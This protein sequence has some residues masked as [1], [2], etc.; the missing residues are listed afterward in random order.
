MN[1]SGSI[2]GLGINW[3]FPVFRIVLIL[4]GLGLTC[5]TARVYAQYT[6]LQTDVMRVIPGDTLKLSRTKILPGTLHTEP[7]VRVLWIDYASG[8]LVLDDIKVD[9]INIYYRWYPGFLAEE[10]AFRKFIKQ[11]ETEKPGIG[12]SGFRQEY[13]NNELFEVSRIRRSG[14]ISRGITAG[15]NRDVSVTSG[16]RLQLEG[17][18][19]EDI[20]ILAAITDENIPIQ[21]DGSTQQLNDFD[22][23][24]IQLKK[25]NSRLT[26]GDFEINRKGTQF[27]DFYRNVQGV[28]LDI[29]HKNIQAGVNGAVAKGK[30]HSNSFMGENGRQGPYRLSGKTGERFIIVLAGSE[31]VYVNG[32]LMLRG[33]GNDYTMDY[34]TGELIFTTQRVITNVSR[35]VVDFEYTDRF[36]NRSLLFAHYSDTWLNDKLKVAWSY[37]READNQNAP[38]DPFSQPQKQVLQAAGD[39]PG[40]AA[41]S[42]VDTAGVSS[43][44]IRYARRDTV[45]MG[46]VYERYVYASQDEQAIYKIS[47]SSVGTGNGYYIRS[48]TEI[49]GT[50]FEWV[51]PDSI[52]GRLAGDYA[53][54]TLLPLPRLLQVNDLALNY[55]LTDKMEVFSETALSIEDKNRFSPKDDKDNRGWANRTG[56]RAGGLKLGSSALVNAELSQKFVSELYQNIDRIYRMEYGREWNFNDLAARKDE[57]VTEGFSEL[58]FKNGLRFKAGGGYRMMGTDVRSVRQ[59]YEAGSTHKWLQGKYNYTRLQTR[60]DSTQLISRWQR[61]T[62][63]IYHV[64]GKIK[65]GMEIWMEEKSDVSFDSMRAGSFRFTDLKPYLRTLDSEKLKLDISYNYRRDYEFRDS[66]LLE[67]AVAHTQYYKAIFTPGDNL[68]FQ[69][70]TTY[71]D[72]QLKNDVFADQGLNNSKVL[73]NN[74]QNTFSTPNR[75]IL[76]NLIYEVTSQRLARREIRYL[77][78]TPGFGQYEWKDF[79]GNGLQELSEFVIS[80]DPSRANFIRLLVPSQ[81]LFPTVGLN[82]SGNLK[83]ELKRVLKKSKN[84]WKETIRNFSTV[85]NFRTEQRKESLSGLN[86]YLINFRDFFKDTSLLNALYNFR[87]DVY[88]FRNSSGGEL[89]FSLTD[90][91]SRLFLL[92]GDEQRNSRIWQSRQRVNFSQDISLENTLTRGNKSYTAMLLDPRNYNISSN[93]VAP[94]LNCQFTRQFRMSYGVDISRKENRNDSL[95]VDSKA[96]FQ[97]LITELKLNFRDRNNVFCK[98]EFIRIRQEGESNAAAAYEM[99]ESFRKGNNL[100]FQSFATWYLTSSLELSLNYELR[101]SEG[102]RPLH[103]GRMQVRAL[104]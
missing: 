68:S 9:S 64:Q 91:K 78:T 8:R 93:S 41:F 14:S 38:I 53:P 28:G 81:E 7:D 47:F 25:Q 66:A 71:R 13:G 45:I 69:N 86:T 42:G 79:N 6:R 87:Q 96:R 15:S 18:V 90:S 65:P 30:F 73:M 4:S 102:V 32:Q 46:V 97:R 23:V 77:E 95:R 10:Y 67:K 57:K 36:Y 12:S 2:R 48:R 88:F 20:E 40:L 100:Y 84:P 52:T 37:G 92:S 62:G 35:I 76:S 33:E 24:Y 99:L 56:V 94:L 1:I 22:K 51:P 104:F 59:I 89:V 44:E 50:I 61:H 39:N 11:A 27:A 21:P 17:Y 3:F 72:F 63:D 85:T 101:A 74:F 60:Y 31:K 58:V 75:L 43:L 83:L 103:T 70:T 80:Y 19:T 55:A 26:L 34:N 49:N 29:Q 98:L 54:L 82:F 16:L 5:S